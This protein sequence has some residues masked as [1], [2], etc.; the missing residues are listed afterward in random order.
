MILLPILVSFVAVRWI[1]FKLLEIA[2][3]KDLVDH[4]GARKLQ[5]VP[6]PVVG[7]LLVFFGLM[8]GTLAGCVAANV[9]A[10]ELSM[11]PLGTLSSNTLS[12]ILAMGVMLYIGFMD[13]MLGL[14]P[15]VRFIVEILVILGL[16][17]STGVCVDSLYGLWGVEQLSVW[18]AIPLTVFAG[19]GI[20]NAINILDG[21]NG[22]SSGICISISLFC[23]THFVLSSYL[24]NALLAFCLAAPLLLFFVHNV[25][26][27][28]SRMF[29]GDSGT[30]LLGIL[31]TWF[32]LSIMNEGKFPYVTEYN[33]C[34]TAMVVAIFA[35]PVADTLRVMVMR[36]IN[37]HSPFSPDN[38]HLHHA[39][40][41]L[42]FSHSVTTFTEI[43]IGLM[44]VASLCVS[45]LFGATFEWQLYTVILVAAVFVWG[46]Y[47]FLI[48]EQKSNSRKAQWL[49][50]LAMRTHLSQ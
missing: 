32:V 49:R 42:G 27:N 36:V 6:V 7:G 14:S 10:A 23:A 37:G 29:M 24:G 13:D 30:M 45:I 8:F 9:F 43:V 12:V 15:K 2:K 4:P 47:F 26:G 33:V 31:M 11:F 48:H 17:G 3:E 19:V 40:V 34:P 25:Y 50:S 16:V 46:T 35:V 38:T 41:A 21:I 28:T 1:Y 5:K 18:V 44:V 39:F 20:I 22:L